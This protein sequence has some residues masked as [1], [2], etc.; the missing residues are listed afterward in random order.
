LLLTL[1]YAPGGGVLQPAGRFFAGMASNDQKTAENQGRTCENRDG[2]AAVSRGVVPAVRQGRLSSFPV[3]AVARPS[4]L[5]QHLAA[6][7]VLA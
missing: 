6:H 1:S 3:G 4:T 2:A 5:S 7:A